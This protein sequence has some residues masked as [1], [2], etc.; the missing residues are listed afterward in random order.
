MPFV[1]TVLAYS[2][3][4]HNL[5]D[6]KSLYQSPS[7]AK[8]S[9]LTHTCKR[10]RSERGIRRSSTRSSRCCQTPRGRSEKRIFG[11]CVCPED[12]A[13]QRFPGVFFL[14]GLLLFEEL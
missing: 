1:K 10:W 13:D 3:L 9:D 4:P 11:N 14:C 2:P 8:G 12:G 6:P 5:N 7:G